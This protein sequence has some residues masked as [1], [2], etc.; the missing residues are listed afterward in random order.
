ML[1]EV[2]SNAK[3]IQCVCLLCCLKEKA[4]VVSLER[5]EVLNEFYLNSC[6]I[7]INYKRNI[8]SFY[9][10]TDLRYLRSWESGNSYNEKMYL[11]WC[12]GCLDIPW[13][14]SHWIQQKHFPLHGWV[15]RWYLSPLRLDL[16]ALQKVQWFIS[17]APF[18]N[19]EFHNVTFRGD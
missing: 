13:N 2:W 19:H 4:T 1:F 18:L 16:L 3:Q 12:I 8:I 6:S 15:E 5:W 10:I 11:F 7:K 14:L 17:A 9:Q